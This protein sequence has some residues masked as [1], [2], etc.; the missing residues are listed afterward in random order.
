MHSADLRD[1]IPFSGHSPSLA[2]PPLA[3][4]FLPEDLFSSM[5]LLWPLLLQHLCVVCPGSARPPSFVYRGYTMGDT[6]AD[7]YDI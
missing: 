1:K 2:V 7:S 3:T 4:V 5:V 6:E